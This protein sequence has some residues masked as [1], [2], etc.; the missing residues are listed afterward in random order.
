MKRSKGSSYGRILER[1]KNLQSGEQSCAR[2]ILAWMSCA[3]FPLQKQEIIQA[4]MVRENDSS[5]VSERKILNDIG[6][7]CGPIIES[8]GDIVSFVHYTA[9]E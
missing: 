5:L 8:E 9:K 7:L 1:I 3:K 4:L 2:T 6:Q